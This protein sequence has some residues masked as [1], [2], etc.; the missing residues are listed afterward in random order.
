MRLREALPTP[1]RATATRV[2]AIL[3][4]AADHPPKDEAAATPRFPHGTRLRLA[5]T[6]AGISVE[7]AAVR[8]NRTA[9]TVTSYELG[10][11]EPPIHVLVELADMYGTTVGVLIGEV[12]A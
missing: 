7:R 4:S 5:R 11:V 6:E 8:I 3:A 10:R 1:D 12:H 2:A 9:S